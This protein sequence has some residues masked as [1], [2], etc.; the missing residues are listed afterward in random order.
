MEK[1][2]TDV[3]KDSPSLFQEITNSCINSSWWPIYIINCEYE[4]D[5]SSYEHISSSEKKA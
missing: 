2:D 3:V 4:S 5:L 1:M